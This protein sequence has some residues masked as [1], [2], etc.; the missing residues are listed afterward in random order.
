M[1]LNQAGQ[2]W[3]LDTVYCGGGG[4]GL[5]DPR[6]FC[7]VLAYTRYF[8]KGPCASMVYAWALKGSRHHILT[9]GPMCV[10][11]RYLDLLGLG[12]PESKDGS[13]STG[14]GFLH[15]RAL[16]PGFQEPFEGDTGTQSTTKT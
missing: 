12:P 2:A 5:T 10:R 3:A 11:Y 9:L 14:N 8:P 13:G 16:G 1:T 6:P 15:L 4:A 7:A